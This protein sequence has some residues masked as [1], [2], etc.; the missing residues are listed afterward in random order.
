MYFK[1][2]AIGVDNDTTETYKFMYTVQPFQYCTATGSS[3]TGADYIDYVSLNGI[4]NSSGQDYY[5][6]FT[7]IVIPLY[8]DST[9]TL[10]VDLNYH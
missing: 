5:G 7:N 9:Y 1:V 8:R 4:Q 6:D 3:G 10:Q 2:F